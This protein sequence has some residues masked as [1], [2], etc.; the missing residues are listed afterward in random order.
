MP[1]ILGLYFFLP[2]ISFG[3]QK[4][5]GWLLL[6]IIAIGFGNWM[7]LPCINLVSQLTGSALRL[8]WLP[9]LTAGGGLYGVYLL[10]G[11]LLYRYREALKSFLAHAGM[12]LVS[13]ILIAA[14]IG[15]TGYFQLYSF[16]SFHEFRIWYDWPLLIII[17][18]LIWGVLVCSSSKSTAKQLTAS[19]ADHSFGMYL[20]HMPI[21][22]IL[23]RF[24]PFGMNRFLYLALL[25]ALVLLLSWITAFL[26]SRIPRIGKILFYRK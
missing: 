5:P 11:Y 3:A 9:D 1:L 18:L 2:Y 26:G 20:V 17:C 8:S 22:L 19:L 15:F 7:I 4:L 13:V 21:I 24:R 25:F 6:S 14:L 16:R 12:V 23:T 10:T